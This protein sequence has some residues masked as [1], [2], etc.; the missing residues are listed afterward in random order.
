M[1][2]IYKVIWSKA[3]QCKIVVSEIAHNLSKCKASIAKVVLS[4]FALSF[5]YI[6]SVF[7]ASDLSA[8]QLVQIYKTGTLIGFYHNS[9]YHEQT[10]GDD[11]EGSYTT[12]PS[13]SVYS[14]LDTD[15]NYKV[16][17]ISGSNLSKYLD[18]NIPLSSFDSNTHYYG[19]YTFSDQDVASYVRTGASSHKVGFLSSY[20]S[21]ELLYTLNSEQVNQFKQTGLI[22]NVTSDGSI[23]YDSDVKAK[24]L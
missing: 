11:V 14:F 21:G 2:R 10:S 23:E 12:I 3:K 24:R 5:N 9:V 1:N 7:A 16:A 20:I 19:G 17:S 6:P 8:A 15:G 13:F 18:K 22:S 4:I